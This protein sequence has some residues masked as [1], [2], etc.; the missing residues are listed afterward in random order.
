MQINCLLCHVSFVSLFF[1]QMLFYL[2]PNLIFI[3]INRFSCMFFCDFNKKLRHAC[4]FFR[5]GSFI[6][7]EKSTKRIKR[8][9]V[10]FYPIHLMQL[11]NG[12]G[13]QKMLI[14]V[15]MVGMLFTLIKEIN[16]DWIVESNCLQSLTLQSKKKKKLK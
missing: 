2:V 7:E 6:F 1:F 14:L 8:N 13:T 4:H 15:K 11:K 5:V 12:E 9:Y 3:V 16:E 10:L